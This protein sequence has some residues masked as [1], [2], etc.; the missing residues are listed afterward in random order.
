[1]AFTQNFGPGE[2]FQSKLTE[3]V[4]EGV[5]K[6]FD[7]ANAGTATATVEL[8]FVPDFSGMQTGLDAS[9]GRLSAHGQGAPGSGDGI[10]GQIL[11][12]LRAC[13]KALDSGLANSKGEGGGGGNG[14]GGGGGP[15]D[16]DGGGH[17]GGG[18]GNSWLFPNRNRMQGWEMQ[19]AM[20]DPAGFV[21]GAVM[22]RWLQSAGRLAM[23][24]AGAGLAEIG[25]VGSAGLIGAALYGG[26]KIG[27]YFDN[28]TLGAGEKEIGKRLS[29]DDLGY[30][31]GVDF[32]GDNYAD[33]VRPNKMGTMFNYRYSRSGLASYGV[34]FRDMAESDR[35]KMSEQAVWA[36]L[37]AK[38]AGVDPGALTGF[39]G[40]SWASGV[41]DKTVEG[42]TT[43]LKNILEAVRQGN[44]IGV[45]GN[46]TM[47]SV[48]SLMRMEQAKSGVIS[49]ASAGT[50]MDYEMGLGAFDKHAF[51]GNKAVGILSAAG[52]NNNSTFKASL[53][54]AMGDGKGGLSARGLAAWASLPAKG[55]EAMKD[56]PIY[57]KMAMLASMPS[58][59]LLYGSDWL[60]GEGKDF[61]PEMQGHFLGLDGQS[62]YQRNAYIAM[63]KHGRPGHIDGKG[64]SVYGDQKGNAADQRWLGN[65]E[66]SAAADSVHEISMTGANNQRLLQIISKEIV[67]AEAYEKASEHIQGA[68]GGL[69][70][71]LGSLDFSVPWDTTHGPAAPKVRRAGLFVGAHEPHQ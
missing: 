22:G 25:A 14:G 13:R 63:G 42:G 12:E 37:A 58:Q 7:G 56:L 11:E 35:H 16:P 2:G 21:G 34:D 50:L 69:I 6:G 5:T 46:E 20:N 44:L 62:L 57:S 53:L 67:V 52:N 54:S 33:R 28:A 15:L 59:E 24:G 23:G 1:M 45:R 31:T 30:S 70:N 71:Y 9:L 51:G 43:I 36:T 17:G 41:G 60:H 32:R 3:M 66:V 40:Q 18:G 29:D 39:V 49:S 48:S 47:Q 26:A 55:R 65:E 19:R 8:K 38:H 4:K 27:N 61:A 64:Y 68:V 10:L